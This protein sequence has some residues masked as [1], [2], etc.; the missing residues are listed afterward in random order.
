[1]KNLTPHVFDKHKC[2][3]EWNEFDQH[4]KKYPVLE[5]NKHVLPFFKVRRDL[6]MLIAKYIPRAANADVLAHEYPLYGDFKAD[7]IVGDSSTHNYLLVE[8]EDGRPDSIFKKKA[9]KATPEW[10]PRFECA[11]SQL[12]DW[13]WML[14]DMRSTG[15]FKTDFGDPRAK[16][17]GLIVLG[18]GVALDNQEKSRLRWREDKVMVDSNGV[19]VVSFE[20]LSAALD[21]WLRTY[22]SV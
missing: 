12:V 21:S 5:E 1:M 4:L 14:D 7:L 3:Q 22:H 18:K 15:R 6:S 9:G 11:F 13:L 19:S 8:F 16:F 10:A 20:P 17:H 2:R